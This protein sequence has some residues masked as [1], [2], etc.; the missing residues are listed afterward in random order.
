[1]MKEFK[2]LIRGKFA[3]RYLSAGDT[4]KLTFRQDG[5]PDF[6][7]VTHVLTADQAMIVDEGV[8]F[9]A[10]FEDRRALGALAL[11]RKT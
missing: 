5:L 10:I 6:D 3:P 7:A 8:L 1:M 9:Q 2:E 4:L 11:E